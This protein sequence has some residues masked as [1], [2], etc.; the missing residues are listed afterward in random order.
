MG[1]MMFIVGIDQY[2]LM[3]LSWK[4]CEIKLGIQN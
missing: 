4:F 1:V 3:E 2:V